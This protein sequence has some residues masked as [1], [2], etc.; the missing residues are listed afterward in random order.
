MQS[1]IMPQF[2]VCLSVCPSMTFKYHDHIGWNTSKMMSASRSVQLLETEPS[3]LLVLGCGTVCQQTLL[4]VTHFRGSTENLKRFYFG[5]IIP[6]FCCSYF[7]CC[8]PCTCIM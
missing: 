8:G 3:P 5:T 6:L 7:S 1:A 4:C 2:V